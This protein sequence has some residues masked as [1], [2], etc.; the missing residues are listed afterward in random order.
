[1]PLPIPGRTVEVLR[2]S[3]AFISRGSRRHSGTGSGLVLPDDRVVTNAHV[4]AGGNLSIESWEGKVVTGKL[5][6]IDRTRDLALLEA[7]GLGAPAASF[8]DSTSVRAGMPV[9]AVGN[10]LGFKGAVSTG[11]VHSFGSGGLGS[12]AADWGSQWICADIRLAPGNSG[13]PLADW[14]GGVVGINTMVMA[15]A[16]PEVSSSGLALAVPSR[17]VLSFLAGTT[18]RPLG[19][20]VRPVNVSGGQS[21]GLGLLILEVTTG[22]AASTASLLPGDILTGANGKP[23]RSVDDLETMLEDSGDALLTLEFRRGGDKNLRHV[24]VTL[25]VSAAASAMTAAA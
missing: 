6:R 7:K 18:R 23:F 2:R 9:I 4:F 25:P 24:T 5:L 14:S 22:G 17:A 10:P 13:G 19:V 15:A 20:T 21:F 12:R 3:T 1:M 16:M 11:T 8:A